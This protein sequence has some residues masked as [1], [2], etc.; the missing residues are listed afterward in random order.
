[1]KAQNCDAVEMQIRVE[2]GKQYVKFGRQELEPFRYLAIL[3][4][5]VG[6]SNNAA[7]EAFNFNS[8][9]W[10]LEKLKH[11]REELV[12]VAAVAKAFI[13]C[14]DRNKWEGVK[15]EE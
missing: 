8:N 1:M 3:G 13:L 15:N 14:L 2:N 6:E 10:D 5:E 12:Q 9:E 7:I 11:L 4:E